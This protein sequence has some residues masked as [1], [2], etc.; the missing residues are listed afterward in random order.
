MKTLRIFDQTNI[1][2]RN[3]SSLLEREKS[4]PSDFV[5]KLAANTSISKSLEKVCNL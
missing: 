5:Q 3:H 2:G 1:R 4:F